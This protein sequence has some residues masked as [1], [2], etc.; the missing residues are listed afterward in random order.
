MSAAY[1]IGPNWNGSARQ[2]TPNAVCVQPELARSSTQGQSDIALLLSS[3]EEMAEQY[4]Q[5]QHPSPPGPEAPTWLT[6]LYSLV[7]RHHVDDA[8]DILFER[9]DELLSAGKFEMV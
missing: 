8:T 1:D 7:D 9:V 6:E 4:K 5:R 3:L 2:S